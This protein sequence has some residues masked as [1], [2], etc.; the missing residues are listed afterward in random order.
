MTPRLP[1]AWRPTLFGGLVALVC[2]LTVAYNARA[3]RP[4]DRNTWRTAVASVF[5]AAA[6]PALACPRRHTLIV[7][8]KTLPCGTKLTFSYRGH[9]VNAYVGDRGPYIAGREWDLD[10]PV[11]RALHF[12]YGVAT[13]RWRPY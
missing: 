11:M 4:H 1:G 10:L 12:P 13:V 6:E 7:A 9:Q 2:A 8:H 3:A 5:D